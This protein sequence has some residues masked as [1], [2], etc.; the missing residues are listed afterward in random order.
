MWGNRKIQNQY[1]GYPLENRILV[2]GTIT[3]TCDA[4]DD[5]IS[6]DLNPV[7]VTDAL[8]EEN[9]NIQIYKTNELN[10]QLRS[11]YSG[12]IYDIIVL[13]S[14]DGIG[15]M[16]VP[17]LKINYAASGGENS[18]IW[19]ALPENADNL[20]VQSDSN[21]PETPDGTDK[22]DELSNTPAIPEMTGAELDN[23]LLEQPMYVEKTDYIVQDA[24]Y[25]VLYPDM[26]QAV[27][28]NNSGTDVKNAEVAFVA[29]DSNGF[30]V[31][32][33]TSHSLGKGAYVVRCT[34]S[35]VNMLDGTT[36]GKDSGMALD[37]DT[38]NIETFKAIVVSYDD[39]DGNTWKNP[40][41][42]T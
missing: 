36:Y 39:F 19:I 18:S 31:K 28:K 32:I 29:W 3:V 9:A 1:P 40:Y 5:E 33:E 20:P 2:R 10:N 27:I 37:S 7:Y 8:N 26:L 22:S 38:D 42:D 16:T 12:G 34:Y 15:L 6:F 4:T 17:Y 41:F 21:K 24:R 25:K 11:F 14:N 13:G 23:A 30:P 35:D